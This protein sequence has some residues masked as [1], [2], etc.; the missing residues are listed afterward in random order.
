MSLSLLLRMAC[1]GWVLRT[2]CR[3]VCSLCMIGWL[4][5]DCAAHVFLVWSVSARPA[6]CSLVFGRWFWFWFPLSFFRRPLRAG[7]GGA[8]AA[9]CCGLLC[10]GFGRPL[11]LAGPLPGRQAW[12]HV[13]CSGWVMK[14]EGRR[15]G[16]VAV[17]VGRVSVLDGPC[18]VGAVVVVVLCC[19]LCFVCF[20]FE[21]RTE[22]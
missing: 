6:F 9:R 3:P 17:R 15:G 2:A 22:G 12:F 16:V 1:G 7:L 13:P 11:V 10:F 8:A 18:R 14:P 21:R 4:A 19:A 5:A 20:E